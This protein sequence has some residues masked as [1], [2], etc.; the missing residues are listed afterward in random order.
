LI[1]VRGKITVPASADAKMIEALALKD[2]KV[3]QMMEGKTV[4]TVIVVP[5]KIINIVAN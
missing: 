4:R 3:A 2:E 1:K 5:G